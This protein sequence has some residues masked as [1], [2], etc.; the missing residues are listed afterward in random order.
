MPLWK[1]FAGPSAEKLTRQAEALLQQAQWGPAKV[2]LER[3]LAKT[4]D[5]VARDRLQVEIG[6]CCDHLASDHLKQAALLAEGGHHRDA[7]EL[8]QLALEV[9]RD[10]R[11]KER[12]RRDG[13]QLGAAAHTEIPAP[14]V[15]PPERRDRSPAE[16][17]VAPADEATFWALIGTLPED[18]QAAYEAYGEPFRSGYLALNQGDFHRAVRRLEAAHRDHPQ[19]GTYIPLELAAAYAHV[20]RGAEACRLLEV[21]LRYHPDILPAYQL[22]CDLLWEMQAFDAVE[23][24]LSAVP[25]DLLDSVALVLL[26][27]ENF[28]RSGRFDVGIRFLRDVLDRFGW[29]EPVAQ[30]LAT[31]L[32]EAGESTAAR[33]LY[34]E[35]MHRCQSCHSRVDPM[36]KHR[37]AELSFADGQRDTAL[38]ELYLSL[39]QDF[40]D[41]AKLYFQ[42]V[43]AIYADQGYVQ[44][45]ERFRMLSERSAMR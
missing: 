18:M 10:P 43:S 17:G 24:L 14:V 15:L 36:V 41:Q 30:L 42:R 32:A 3:A 35:I 22:Y 16:M 38:L 40:P 34:G 6:T 25:D 5:P 2:A 44:E 39:A 37:Y 26:R 8:I 12:A 33:S 31:T 21:F 29:H 9:A 13:E 28:L 4:T 45:A 1:L 19:A 23:E 11:L 27:G 20:G 7:G